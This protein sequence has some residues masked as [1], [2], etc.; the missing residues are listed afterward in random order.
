MSTPNA[1][2]YVVCHDNY[3]KGYAMLHYG[4]LPFVRLHKIPTT[5]YFE[6][7]M[8]IE[9]IP[10]LQ[11]EWEAKDYVGTITWRAKQKMILPDF[12]AELSKAK[13]T[14]SDVIVFMQPKCPKQQNMINWAQNCHRHF[15]YLWCIFCEQLGYTPE[16]YRSTEFPAFYC[17]YWMAKPEWMTKYVAHVQKAYDILESFDTEDGLFQKRLNSNS[18]FFCKVPRPGIPYVTYHCFLMERLPC[19]FFWAQGAKIHDATV[20]I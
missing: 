13:R 16:Q 5:Q 18:G 2:L 15:E 6:S 3:S 1:M 12:G 20:Q 8:Y 4:E 14:D 10:S 19:L 9:S 7:H 11:D 17:N